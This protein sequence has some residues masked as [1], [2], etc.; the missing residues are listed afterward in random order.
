MVGRA[1]SVHGPFVDMNSTPMLQGGGSQLL[2][3][4]DTQWNAP[5]GQSVF[6]DPET[7]ITSI[8]FHS[9][10]LPAGTPYLLKRAENIR[11]KIFITERFFVELLPAG[12][13]H[14]GRNLDRSRRWRKLLPSGI[15]CKEFAGAI[16]RNP[17]AEHVI[18]SDHAVGIGG[19]FGFSGHRLLQLPIPNSRNDHDRDEEQNHHRQT[20]LS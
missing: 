4:S 19:I 15:A 16:G 8:V 7:N 2:A 13:N 3:G 1:T 6:T 14:C 18:A 11:Q 20:W 9:H 12:I 10:R 17:G 5:G